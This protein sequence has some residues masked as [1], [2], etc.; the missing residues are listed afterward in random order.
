MSCSAVEIRYLQIV[1]FALNLETTSQE[2]EKASSPEKED[3]AN[4][5]APKKS[6]KLSY[7]EY[8]QMANLLVL[9]MRR[10]EE[11]AKGNSIYSYS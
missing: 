4:A 6:I 3:A 1:Y 5:D 2:S 7:D 9:Y 11:E 8:R 10:K